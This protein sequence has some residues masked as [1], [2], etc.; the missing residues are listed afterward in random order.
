MEKI[1]FNHK[2]IKV[3]LRDEVDLSIFNEIFKF[4]EYRQNEKII[5]KAKDAIIDVGAHAG[6]FSLYAAAFN[7]NV[8]I[9]ALEPEPNNFL[10]LNQNIKLN[11]EF[12]KI[13]LVNVALG[14]TAGQAMLYLSAD[15]HNH[16]FLKE[17]NKTGKELPVKT[18][19]LNYFCLKQKIAKISLLKMDIEGG[20]HEIIKNFSE[21]EWA[22][23]DNLFL[24]VHETKLGFYQSLEK[25]IRPNGFSVQIFPCQF[26]HNLKF[27]LAVNKRKIKP[28]Y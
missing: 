18:A 22:L 20:E 11:P 25:I 14:S 12:K 4:R 23:I 16:S 10:A 26:A 5:E 17:T 27:M 3:I 19:S 1:N 21:A 13:K 8:K 24:E 2:I 7:S 9:Y 6:F 28:S 15:S